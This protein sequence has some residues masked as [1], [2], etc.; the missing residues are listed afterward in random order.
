[1]TVVAE[2]LRVGLVGAGPWA[3]AVHAP[4]LAAHPGVELVSVWGRRHDVAAGLAA[5]HGA[6]AVRE[7]DELL[8]QVDAVAFAVPPGVQAPIAVTAAR[9]GRHLVLE[10]PVAESV[11]GA[12]ELVDAVDEAGVAALVMLTRRFAPETRE[13]L[14]D[15]RDLGGWTGGAA[16][17]V[18]GGLLGGPYSASPWRHERGALDDVGPHAFDLLDAALGRITGVRAASCAGGLWQVLLEHESGAVSSAALGMSVP[19]SPGVAEL[20]VFGA[21]GRR[22]L[23]GRGSTARD[24][25]AVLLDDLVGAVASGA[26]RHPCDVRRGLHLQRVIAEVRALA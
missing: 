1:M 16:R 12:R 13:Q 11:A 21:H 9:R 10:K 18:G 14:V 8:E 19:V 15:W 7:V 22:V 3:R 26:V 17:W 20:E 4:G 2:R 24:C 5:E 25:Y 23:A 6:A